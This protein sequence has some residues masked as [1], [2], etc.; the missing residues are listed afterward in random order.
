MLQEKG[1]TFT[2]LYRHKNGSSQEVL[3]VQKQNGEMFLCKEQHQSWSCTASRVLLRDGLHL[4]IQDHQERLLLLVQKCS[5]EDVH[6]AV[7][8]LKGQTKI[9]I[10]REGMIACH[11]PCVSKQHAQLVMEQGEWY[12]EDLQSKNG[13]YVN[14]KRCQRTRLMVGDAIQLA[15]FTFLY[16]KS[17]LYICCL[18]YT[19][20]M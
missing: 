2:W 9:T 17:H 6:Y 1:D 3:R 16:A 13:V 20:F 5:P 8:S 11:H 10:G 19:S 18:L 7:Y 4:W 12:I 14:Q 15:H